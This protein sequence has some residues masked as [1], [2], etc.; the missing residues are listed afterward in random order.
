MKNSYITDTI[1]AIA[2]PLGNGGVSIIRI[3]GENSFKIIDKIFTY[4]NLNAGRIYHGRIIENNQELDDVIVLPFRSPKSYTGEDVIEIHCH[5]G[6]YIT[7]KILELVIQQGAR[8]AEKGE[9]TKRAFINGKMDLSQAE[10]VLDLIH[11]NSEQFAEKSAKNLFG[12]LSIEITQ[13]RQS[14]MEL[15]SGI[16]AAV[17]FPEDVVE[18]EYEFIENNIEKILEKINYILSFSKSS[19]VFRQG[20]KIVLAGRPNVGKSSLFNA[21]LNFNIVIFT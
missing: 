18:P 5:G 9:F 19:N 16:I 11:A 20:I 8:Y 17:D 3:S 4:H 21:L 13:I 1:A 15:L 10:A 7:K 14:I 12:K 6:V 2:T